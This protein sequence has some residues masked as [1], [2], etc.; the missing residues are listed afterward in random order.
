[1]A[2]SRLTVCESWDGIVPALPPR[3]RLYHLAPVGVGTPYVE[4]LTGYVARLAEAHNVMT[5]TLIR[6]ELLPL[7]G[8]GPLTEPEDIPLTDYWRTATR[9]INGTRRTARGWTRAL[10]RL[11]M[12]SE[13]RFL[14]LQPWAEVLSVLKLLRPVRAWCPACYEEWRETGQEVYEP[15]LW[16]IAA[17]TICPRHRRRLSTR[18]PQPDCGRTS[19]PLESQSRPGYCPTC[20]RWLGMPLEMNLMNDA[21][22]AGEDAAWR[23]WMA[24]SIGEVLAA[25][26]TLP[27]LPHRERIA[28]AMAACVQQSARGKASVLAQA[29]GLRMGGAW[30][31]LHGESL[32]QLD[33][34]LRLCDLLG[35]S[36]LDF[37]TAED[38]HVGPIRTDRPWMRASRPQ[39]PPRRPFDAARLRQALEQVLAGEEQPPP[40]MREVGRRLAYGACELHRHFP[41]LC[42]AISARHK[43]YLAARC[44]ERRRRLC[45]EVREVVL[46]LYGQG[47]YPS[48]HRVAALLRIPQS[49]RVPEVQAT[50]RETL[51][52]LGW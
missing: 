21:G 3:S 15:L 9:A 19:L 20:E 13:L 34:L 43:A 11:T 26:P 45:A 35:I 39:A 23:L 32:P 17:V 16:A 49:M 10:E 4:S 42:S 51:Q 25:S 18:C 29:L 31:W 38:L 52:E 47:L 48:G 22:L 24:E 44:R 46:T 1:M 41:E 8:A 6:R 28:Q 50:W 12:R 5:L 14:T 40:S 27:A 7:L 30:A 33:L 2:S 37:L 36:L